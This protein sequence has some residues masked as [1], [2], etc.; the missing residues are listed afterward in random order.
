MSE[1][2]DPPSAIRADHSMDLLNNLFRQPVDP[3]YALSQGTGR[4]GTRWGML[5]VLAAFG[6]M[7]TLAVANTLRLAPIAETERAQLISRIR[8]EAAQHQALRVRVESLTSENRALSESLLDAATEETMTRQVTALEVTTGMRPVTGEGVVL[9][10]DDAPDANSSSNRVVDIDLRQAVNGL[11]QSGAE[12]IA[13]NGHRLSARTAIRAA[14]DAI[15]VDYRSLTRPYRIEAIGDGR[16]LLSAFPETPGG[17][18]W[19]YL[20]LNF[21]I[22][23]EVSLAGSLRL[24]ADPGL[25]VRESKRAQ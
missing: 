10:M 20:R 15:T 13:V 16:A 24:R 25:G 19:A 18:W 7:A 5:A 3:D 8:D 17:S 1:Q 21:G 11:W 23:Y 9:V 12:A 4:A 22:Q 14:G 2:P 6:L